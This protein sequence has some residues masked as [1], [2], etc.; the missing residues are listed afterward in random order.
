MI[1]YRLG[2]VPGE[3]CAE[4]EDW[5]E[6]FGA[7]R[8]AKKRRAELIRQD[9]AMIGCRVARDYEICRIKLVDLPPR[10]LALAVLNRRYLVE[11]VEVVGPYEPGASLRDEAL[12]KHHFDLWS[13]GGD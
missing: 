4:G 2:I 12:K 3:G 1:L 7:L 6:W 10:K 9:P 13:D 11:S 5:D 8:D